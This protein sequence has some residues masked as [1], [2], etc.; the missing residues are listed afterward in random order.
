MFLPFLYLLKI[1]INASSIKGIE[2]S[3]KAKLSKSDWALSNTVKNIAPKKVLP[4]SPI[5]NFDGC[6][7]KIKKAKIEAANGTYI[8]S[9][10]IEA[11]MK[12]TK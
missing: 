2:I 1:Q 10:V 4:I 3:K 6:Q 9:I 8:L 5:N 7:L 11:I 12:I